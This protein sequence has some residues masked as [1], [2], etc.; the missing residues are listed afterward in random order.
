MHAKS[1][2]GFTL[3][4]IM[5]A[6]TIIS[7]AILSLGSFSLGVVGNGQ[8][9]RERLTAIHLAEQVLE[10]W[11]N[12]ANNY[13]PVIASS[14]TFTT[15]TALPSYPLTSACTPSSGVSANFSV[16]M[17]ILTA[18]APLPT[19]PNANNSN[20]GAFAVRNM[21][22]GAASNPIIKVATVS[23]SHKG[24]THSVSLTGLAKP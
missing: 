18:T 21:I 13:A 20:A 10:F 15:A 19:N 4:E 14:C 1:P 23:W 9:D 22:G 8:M 7:V 11:Q 16:Q 2:Q 24:K 12:D 17:A 3:I 5:V 6:L